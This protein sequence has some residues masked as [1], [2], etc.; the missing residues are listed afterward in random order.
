M[1]VD[2]WRSRL[3]TL[4]GVCQQMKAGDRFSG[5]R[6]SAI[7]DI[8][9][10][11]TLA[12]IDA[13]ESEL[14]AKIPIS[15]RKVLLA[16]SARIRVSWQLPEFCQP[17][18]PF[19]IFSGECSW[20]LSNLPELHKQYQEQLGMMDE[21]EDEEASRWREMFPFLRVGNGDYIV[22]DVASPDGD[23]VVYSDHEGDEAH[24]YKLGET[25]AD[26]V[27]RLTQLACVGPEYWQWMPFTDGRDSRLLVD[28]EA[29]EIWRNWMLQGGWKRNA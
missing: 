10:P 2:E 8:A 13:V 18:H 4:K 27:D 26:Y 7:F 28:C 5:G 22:I 15:F 1:S 6:G 25:F 17:P 24:G 23:A 14:G 19:E 21:G 12:D 29:A 16:F 9:P 20:D 11:A 3:S